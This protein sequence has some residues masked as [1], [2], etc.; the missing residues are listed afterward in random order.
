MSNPYSRE[1]A[2][3]DK[4]PAEI[5]RPVCGYEGTYEISSFGQVRSV[6]RVGVDGRLLKGRIMK[7]GNDGHGYLQVSLTK[8]NIRGTFKIHRLVASAFVGGRTDEDN[9]VNHLDLNKT[10]NRA[11]NL[12]WISQAGNNRHAATHGAESAFLNPRK[13]VL[14]TIEVLRGIQQDLLS[15]ALSYPQIARKFGVSIG[16]V[17]NIRAGKQWKIPECV[18]IQTSPLTESVVN[19]PNQNFRVDRKIVISILD[20]LSAGLTQR[21]TARKHG[22][23]QGLVKNISYGFHYLV[24]NDLALQKKYGLPLRRCPAKARHFNRSAI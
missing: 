11:D 10:N 1:K 5:W 20:D 8:N 12:E 16:T 9:T 2:M 18:T 21:A 13:R 22:V 17:N 3:S 4:A 15:R 6:S 7:P 14:V 24:V 19:I 23:S